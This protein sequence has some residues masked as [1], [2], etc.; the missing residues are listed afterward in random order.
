MHV[1][2][3]QTS[4]MVEIVEAESKYRVFNNDVIYS[5]QC[6]P[7]NALLLFDKI[8]TAYTTISTKRG[9]EIYSHPFAEVDKSMNPWAAIHKLTCMLERSLADSSPPK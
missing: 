5:T 2:Y 7:N 8:F 1:T 9:Y 6:N 3:N 4:E